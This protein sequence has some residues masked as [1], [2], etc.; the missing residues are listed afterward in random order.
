MTMRTLLLTLLLASAAA[1]AQPI[2]EIAGPLPPPRPGPGPSHVPSPEE[3][4]TVPELDAAQQ[5]EV[6]KI[7][8]QRRDAHDALRAT[9][10]AEREAARSRSRAE[11][12]RIDD[13][14]STRLRKLLGEDRYRKLATWLAP[15]RENVFFRTRGPMGPHGPAPGAPGAA[16]DDPATDAPIAPDNDG[17]DQ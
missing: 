15:R 8:I 2:T 16:F 14:S 3:L 17:V 13:D 5:A 7:L 12:E 1:A 11:H 6:R 9:E 10:A 4:A